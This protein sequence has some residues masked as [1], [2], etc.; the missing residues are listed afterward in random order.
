[1]VYRLFHA[2]SVF[3]V[4]LLAVIAIVSCVSITGR[5]LTDFGLRPVPGDFELVEAGTALAA[6]CFMPLCHLSRGHASVD[7]FYQ[8]FP[9][10]V[11]QAVN[12]VC[13]LLM[14]ALWSVISWRTFLAALEFKT[15]GELTFILQFPIW[16]PV[17]LCA[18]VSLLGCVGYVYK[19]LETLG[20]CQPPEA[21]L[22]MSAAEKH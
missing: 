2:M 7:L 3:G 1:M 17:M 11:K 22:P 4:G 6:F 10:A 16:W 21:F 5:A 14:L 20:V 8:G 13:D 12:L 18:C 15:N 9:D 19:V